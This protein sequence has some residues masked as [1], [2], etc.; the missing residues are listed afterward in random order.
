MRAALLDDSPDDD[1]AD[2]VGG[3]QQAYTETAAILGILLDQLV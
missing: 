2:P 3:P 1:V